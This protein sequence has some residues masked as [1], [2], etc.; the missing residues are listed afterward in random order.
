MFHAIEEIRA[1]DFDAIILARQVLSGLP[2]DKISII[3]DPT[4]FIPSPAQGALAVEIRADDKETKEIVS[5]LDDRDARIT[6]TAEREVFSAL[7]CGCHAP[8][9]VFAK[10]QGSEITIWACFADPDGGNQRTFISI[11][12]MSQITRLAETG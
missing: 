8:A 5:K 11:M 4:K 7:G 9:G 1:G 6:S 10:T 3:F 2:A 12:P